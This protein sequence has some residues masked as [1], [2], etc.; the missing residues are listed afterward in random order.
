MPLQYADYS[1]NQEVTWEQVEEAR[2]ALIAS[3]DEQLRS[4][5][6]Q[7]EAKASRTR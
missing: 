7:Q 4:E 6:T 1:I 5:P 3:L 2:D